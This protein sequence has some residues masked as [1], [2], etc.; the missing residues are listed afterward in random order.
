M[1]LALHW[2][3][4]FEI[5]GI[6]LFYIFTGGSSP[7]LLRFAQHLQDIHTTSRIFRVSLLLRT[8]NL[9]YQCLQV[10]L[11]KMISKVILIRNPYT[12]TCR[13]NREYFRI[14]YHACFQPLLQKIWLV[15]LKFVLKIIVL[16]VIKMLRFVAQKVL[17]I[18]SDN[19]V[20]FFRNNFE[21]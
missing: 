7:T 13:E 11:C 2:V 16:H 18:W 5:C 19:I 10:I 6:G 21:I 20:F 12:Q 9:R 8:L 14:Q 4:L 1:E 17:F 15:I 3:S